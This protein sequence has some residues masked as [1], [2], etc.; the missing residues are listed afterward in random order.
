M[1]EREPRRRSLRALQ[2]AV[3]CI[4]IALAADEVAQLADCNTEASW[5][6]VKR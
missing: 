2:Q 3:G 6:E 5:N 1:H 4:E